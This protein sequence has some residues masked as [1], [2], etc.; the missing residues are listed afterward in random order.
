MISYE[1]AWALGLFS[2]VVCVVTWL[3]VMTKGATDIRKALVTAMVGL[4]S[5]GVL[6]YCVQ[7]CIFPMLIEQLARL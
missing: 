6:F 5:S 3:L 4:V 7:I 1:W 2:L